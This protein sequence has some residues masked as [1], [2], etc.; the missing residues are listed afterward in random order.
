MLDWVQDTI[1]RAHAEGWTRLD[2]GNAGL[3]AIPEEVW[4]LERLEVLVLGRWYYDHPN[5]RWAESAH[6]GPRNAIA[7][8]PEQIARLS[9][10]CELYLGANKIGDV[11]PLAAL[12]N[13]T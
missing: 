4:E 7:I 3:T 6:A 13:L 2:L 12:T 1:R 11:G 10:L 8:I 5:H 9:R